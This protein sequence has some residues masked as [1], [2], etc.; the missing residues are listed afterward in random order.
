MTKASISDAARL[1]NTTEGM[2]DMT[3]PTTPSSMAMGAKAR[4]VVIV[5]ASTAPKT[6]STPS[7]TACARSLPISR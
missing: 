7:R 4:Q 3:R 5:L 1:K 2:I 6:S